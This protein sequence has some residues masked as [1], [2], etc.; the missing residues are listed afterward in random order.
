MELLDVDDL[1]WI[2]IA[3]LD[4]WLLDN[5]DKINKGEGNFVQ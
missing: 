4:K 1:V 2:C 5:I 3:K